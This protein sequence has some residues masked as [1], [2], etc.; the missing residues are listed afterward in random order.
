MTRSLLVSLVTAT[1]LAAGAQASV[2]IVSVQ[3]HASAIVHW[4]ANG[5]DVDEASNSAPGECGGLES[6]SH[7]SDFVNAFS[8]V[9]YASS[10]SEQAMAMHGTH[11]RSALNASGIP[12]SE[13]LSQG[14]VSMTVAFTVD[15]PTLVHVLQSLTISNPRDVWFASTGALLWF[16]GVPTYSLG[17][18]EFLMLQPG[19]YLL[20]YSAAVGVQAVG[21]EGEAIAHEVDFESDFQFIVPVPGGADIDGD[22]LV[23]GADIAMVLGS[24]GSCAGC[25]AGL[26]DDG[27]VDGSDLAVVLGNW[28]G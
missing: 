21:E 22:G 24:W 20:G 26:N 28:T 19:Q 11:A 16:N 12:G 2:T 8:S 7:V 14:F 1:A 17:A 6:A 9:G 27:V 5:A 10:V 13:V 15:A 23:N 25:P 3:R 4:P 18:D